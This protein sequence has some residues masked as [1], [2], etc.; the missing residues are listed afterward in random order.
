M[1]KF[2]FSAYLEKCV[3]LLAMVPSALSHVALL[4]QSCYRPGSPGHW[5]SGLWSLCGPL[6][7]LVLF[8]AQQTW[9]AAG[10]GEGA[11]QAGAAMVP[12]QEDGLT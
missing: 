10:V 1:Q 3:L 5:T 6:T 4:A 12:L 2:R 11:E 9:L 7:C 8:S